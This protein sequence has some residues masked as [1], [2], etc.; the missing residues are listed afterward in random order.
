[1]PRPR[2]VG[3]ASGRAG[4]REHAPRDVSA[5]LATACAVAADRLRGVKSGGVRRANPAAAQ[6]AEYSKP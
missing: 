2:V 5:P 3:G 4:Q 1:M 6:R